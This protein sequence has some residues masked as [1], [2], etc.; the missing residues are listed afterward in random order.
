MLNSIQAPTPVV[1]D[2]ALV[3]LAEL[4]AT[5]KYLRDNNQPRANVVLSI[6]DLR[7][8]IEALA[9]T[10]LVSEQNVLKQYVQETYGLLAV[11]TDPL[12]RPML[13]A[14]PAT[15]SRVRHLVLAMNGKGLRVN[16][17]I[18]SLGAQLQ[19]IGGPATYNTL[20]SSGQTVGQVT[21]LGNSSDVFSL[22]LP[23]AISI[24]PPNTL[25]FF[26]AQAKV[27]QVFFPDSAIGAGFSLL[28]NDQLYYGALQV[29]S[30]NTLLLTL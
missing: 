9:V 3:R 29:T 7:Q 17:K 14:V 10:K 8:K 18:I 13:P 6:I 22:N 11:Y 19:N 23:L 26:I 28:Y 30:D 5:L 15:G 27:G 24:T 1:V 4:G 21:Y 16:T 2:A 12:L 25:T 20:I